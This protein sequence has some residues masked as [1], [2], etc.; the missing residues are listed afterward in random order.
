M[1]LVKL[2][3]EIGNLFG[4][5]KY[6]GWSNEELS[7]KVWSALDSEIAGIDKRIKWLEEWMNYCGEKKDF[8]YE[9]MYSFAV[10]ELRK[11]RGKEI[12]ILQLKGRLKK[13][14]TK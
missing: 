6:H 2:R 4:S 7:N 12:V 8:D 9:R 11:M 1:T 10:D 3:K 5:R 13:E 14:A